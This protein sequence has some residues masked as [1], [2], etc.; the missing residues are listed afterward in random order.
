MIR[1][2][3]LAGTIAVVFLFA[4]SSATSENY[5]VGP[6]ASS[7]E[8]PS[9]LVSPFWIDAPRLSSIL[10]TGI[11]PP[12]ALE[13]SWETPVDTNERE[14]ELPSYP[15][16]G[17]TD[18]AVQG[19]ER[20]WIE[21]GSR[22]SDSMLL[23]PW[24]AIQSDGNEWTCWGRTYQ[25]SISQPLLAQITS[26]GQELF[27]RPMF[28]GI[29]AG[30]R[31]L[32]WVP[33]GSKLIE[34]SPGRLVKVS[35]F[36]A[37][38][39]KLRL[40]TSLEFDGFL[41]L[42]MR[43]IGP[44]RPLVLDSVF[45]DIAMRPEQA[46]YVLPE[47]SGEWFS[48]LPEGDTAGPFAYWLWLGG[49]DV[50][51]TWCTE[52]DQ[53]WRNRNPNRR[54]EIIRRRESTILRL[55]LID[56]PIRL[57]G[58]LDYTFMLQATPVKPLPPRW[59][60]YQVGP[61][62]Y[63]ADV[64]SDMTEWGRNIRLSNIDILKG[65]GCEV[66]MF[67]PEWSDSPQS[68]RPRDEL[69]VEPAFGSL[70]SAAHSAGLKLI[71]DPGDQSADDLPQRMKSLL[72]TFGIDGVYLTEFASPQLS[73][74]EL[75]SS[76]IPDSNHLP[77]TSLGI[78]A[79]RENMKRTRFLFQDG[80]IAAS[81]PGGPFMPTLGFADVILV[82]EQGGSITPDAMRL[83]AYA[84][85]WGL[86]SQ[87][88]LDDDQEH[89]LT[90]AAINGCPFWVRRPEMLMDSN[91]AGAGRFYLM[92]DH[93]H[94]NGEDVDFVP[95]WDSGTLLTV[96]DPEVKCAVYH[97]SI[98]E[99]ALILPNYSEIAKK[100]IVQLNWQALGSS[101]QGYVVTDILTGAIGLMENSK[102]AVDIGPWQVK[103]IFLQKV[104][105]GQT[106]WAPMPDYFFWKQ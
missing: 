91:S 72:D 99:L 80:F 69:G 79:A 42:D 95:Y 93:M 28:L 44:A 25:I 48:K 32:E 57:D 16:S 75:N 1:H 96:S 50:G 43:I 74:N 39:T 98:P 5:A 81:L 61:I 2:F 23:P 92:M 10:A 6:E 73:S 66:S 14:P 103:Y 24:T 101:Y 17:D 37:G 68:R 82:H 55:R 58:P 105:E 29:R 53:N 94:R 76:R 59:R 13:S 84:P 56:R 100:V 8:D 12:A 102:I 64:K 21:A 4:V 51:L 11:W 30:E 89:A 77:R 88:C 41:R 86:P 97:N 47:W 62:D 49:D 106:A 52:T 34:E 7:W 46:K 18:E 65:Y 71:A 78:L 38:S 70:V 35:E 45:L 36:T 83:M 22:Y 9:Q 63:G 19:I 31:E 40:V 27:T 90:L 3:I 20:S 54:I 60:S 104:P 87:W 67:V 33:G 85:R 15:T 26:Q